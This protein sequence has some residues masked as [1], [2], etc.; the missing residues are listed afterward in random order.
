MSLVDGEIDESLRATLEEHMLACDDCLA[1][2]EQ[3]RVVI[4]LA[5]SVGRVDREDPA[6]N[7]SVGRQ[8]L[9]ETFLHRES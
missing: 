2:L 9:I 8:H 4:S 7:D 3:L 1:G 6:P 5:G